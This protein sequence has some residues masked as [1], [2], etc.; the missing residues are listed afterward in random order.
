MLYTGVNDILAALAIGNHRYTCELLRFRTYVNVNKT[1]KARL[2][3]LQLA[4]YNVPL[5]GS[6]ILKNKGQTVEFDVT[7][8]VNGIRPLISGGLLNGVYEAVGVHFHWGSHGYKGSEHVI[9]NY[10]YDGEIHLVH[11]NVKYR[12]TREAMQYADGL[13]A[14][15]VMMEI[16]N[17][18]HGNLVLQEVVNALPY[19]TNHR[20]NVPLKKPITLSGLLDNLDTSSYFTYKGS[21][22][23][24]NCSE[25]LTWHVFPHPI[26]VSFEQMKKFWS[27]RDTQGLPLLNNYRPLQH[28]NERPIK[29]S[30]VHIIYAISSTI[31]KIKI[32]L[33]LH[34]NVVLF[35]LANLPPFSSTLLIS[36]ELLPQ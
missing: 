14:L 33:S 17:V 24:P 7:P 32:N 34:L 28:R 1:T 11:K 27:L 8:T 9:D 5:S 35:T 31:M 36:I 26:L 10:R 13:A 12:T 15:A 21:M 3:S 6:V 22:T 20:S 29:L 23:T 25:A 2:S 16:S 19:I 18:S 4:N 30:K